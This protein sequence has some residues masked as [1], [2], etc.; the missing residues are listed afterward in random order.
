MSLMEKNGASGREVE[1]A[2]GERSEAAAGRAAPEGVPNPELVEGP[3]RRRFTAAYKL[4]ILR[5]A[6]ACTQAGETGALLRREGLYSSHLSSWRKQRAGLAC[7][8]AGIRLAQDPQ[9]VGGG[10]PP[11]LRALDQLGLSLIHI[12]EPTRR[13]P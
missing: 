6:D 9:L 10:K 5:E 12:S 1:R 13:T 7:L 8:R 3:K 11:P 4:R 2:V